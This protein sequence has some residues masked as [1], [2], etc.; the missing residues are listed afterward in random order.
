MTV[1]LPEIPQVTE[2]GCRDIYFGHPV[3]SYA[4]TVEVPA[5]GLFSSRNK[6]FKSLYKA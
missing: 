4:K 6:S 2:H 5:P 3:T 1:H